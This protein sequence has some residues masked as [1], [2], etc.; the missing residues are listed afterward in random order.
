LE[1]K[2]DDRKDKKNMSPE[3]FLKGNFSWW[4]QKLAED[5]KLVELAAIIAKDSSAIESRSRE[6]WTKFA[7]A[8]AAVRSIDRKES[9]SLA[10]RSLDAIVTRDD[11]LPERSNSESLMTVLV[12][13]PTNKEAEFKQTYESMQ[14]ISAA[15]KRRK[16][17]DKLEKAAERK[18]AAEAK[19]KKVTDSYGQ[20]AEKGADEQV[21][22][23]AEIQEEDE[24]AEQ[25]ELA[26]IKG[27]AVISNDVLPDSAQ[28]LFPRGSGEVDKK[29]EFVL[30]SMI[31]LKKGLPSIKAVCRENRYTVR[32]YEFKE[33]A[34]AKG[35]AVKAKLIAEEH[36]TRRQLLLQS[37]T[38]F[39]DLFKYWMHIKALRAV[40]ECTLR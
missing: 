19:A 35:E 18:K 8:R 13:I 11:F 36:A 33:D 34:K 40:V 10:T 3:D 24:P 17:A 6:A 15:N 26:D 1:I 31:I 14:E 23:A 25:A 37:A 30:Y 39:S 20:N 29:E 16:D 38:Y 7:D 28:R 2:V 9:G 4:R 5:K 21:L 32:E 12:V 27:K 22:L